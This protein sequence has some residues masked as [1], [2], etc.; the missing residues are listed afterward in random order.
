MFH[1]E[2]FGPRNTFGAGELAETTLSC[3]AWYID[4]WRPLTMSLGMAIRG[5]NT[6]IDGEPGTIAEVKIPTDSTV[7]LRLHVC[8]DTNV[9]GDEDPGAPWDDP[10]IGY[11]ENMAT[12]GALF[13]PVTVAPY[14]RE[15]VVVDVRGWSYTC[16]VQ[17]LGLPA[18]VETGR[19][20]FG[21]DGRYSVVSKFE[22]EIGLPAGHT[23]GVA[24]GP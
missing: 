9:D 23:V 21:H 5:S 19:G 1:V 13:E 11:E 16:Q 20:V 4:D 14:T 8:G 24:P 10:V 7:S 12:L 3:P 6:I 18:P 22:L 17:T 2:H 15:L